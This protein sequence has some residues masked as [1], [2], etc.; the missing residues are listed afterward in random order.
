MG[1]RST[2]ACRNARML[3]VVLQNKQRLCPTC[4]L[5]ILALF[6]PPRRRLTL[7]A[8][9]DTRRRRCHDERDDERERRRE[10]RGAGTRDEKPRRLRV[11]SE[12]NYA[13]MRG[14]PSP[15]PS[16]RLE[17][18]AHSHTHPHTGKSWPSIAA[19]KSYHRRQPPRNASWRSLALRSTQRARGTPRPRRASCNSG[20]TPA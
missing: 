6:G 4:R 19:L 1:S 11:L 13:C 9:A 12:P 17:V 10:R 15:S 16:T 3:R 2:C 7:L 14:G 18:D 5:R 8:L 20:R